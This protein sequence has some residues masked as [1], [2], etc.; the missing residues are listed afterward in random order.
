MD[1]KLT[2][3]RVAFN[4][5]NYLFFTLFA[6]MCLYPLWYVIIYS[7]SDPD[8]VTKGGVYF[9][10]KGFS[11][12]N[13]KK[14]VQLKGIFPAIG[15]SVLRTVIGTI[16]TVVCCTILGYL[17]SKERMPARKFFYRF[18][19]I[20]MYIGGGM[21]P[22]YL[23]FRS[24]GLLN[25]FAVYILPSMISAY[26]VILI[27]TYVEQLPAELEES[28]MLD[29]ATVL[30]IIFRIVIPLSM[31]IIAT[32]A[33]FA[34]VGHWNSWF[35]NHI[36]TYRNDNLTTLQYILYNY[37]NEAERLAKLI[38]E[39]SATI[40]QSQ[41]M[42]P[43]GVKMTVTLFSLIPILMVYPFL[44][45]YYVKGVMIGAIKG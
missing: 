32:V 36:Y 31:P 4:I 35:D 28:A 33:L 6:I 10:L 3:P 12:Y 16:T 24:Y 18:L 14:V 30:Q 41:Y 45:K 15:I 25:T 20:T 29:G 39:S 11:L 40:D 23:V 44:Q 42:T 13:F 37:M 21:I 26:N 9:F 1:R 8:Q 43:M 22:T 34:A 17:F 7:F 38:Q 5:F 19:I 27:K 2:G